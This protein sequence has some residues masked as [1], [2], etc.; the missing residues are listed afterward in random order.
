MRQRRQINQI[1]VVPYIDVMLVLLIIFMITAPLIQSG[2]VDLPSVSKSSQPQ[3]APLEVVI[4]ADQ[5]ISLKNRAQGDTE[6]PVAREAL[7][8]R[9]AQLRQGHPEQAVLIAAD[10]SVR[11]EAVMNVMDLLQRQRV[12]KIGLLVQPAK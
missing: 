4:H 9:I 12:G 2:S 8:D 10:K 5:R 1:N 6:V 7:A 11:Y 3:I